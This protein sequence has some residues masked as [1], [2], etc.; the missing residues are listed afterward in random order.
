MALSLTKA[1]RKFYQVNTFYQA[2]QNVKTDRFHIRKQIKPP[3][4]GSKCYPLL[5]C[6]WTQ[7]PHLLNPV[8]QKI[9]ITYVYLSLCYISTSFI[10]PKVKIL[11]TFTLNLLKFCTTAYLCET[12]HLHP[13]IFFSGKQNVKKINQIGEN[14]KVWCI[15]KR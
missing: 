15:N 14:T 4:Q 6:C 5:H 13:D 7:S 3:C 9:D 10:T 12:F 8:I 11:I 1:L 2:G